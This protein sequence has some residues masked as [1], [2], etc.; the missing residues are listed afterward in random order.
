MTPVYEVQSSVLWLYSQLFL[1]YIECHLCRCG[2]LI[3]LCRGPHVRHTGKIKAMHVTK[4]SILTV[5]KKIVTL[6]VNKN[7]Q[8]HLVNF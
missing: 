3:D 7:K 6:L 2:P 1:Y 5:F 4:V 8:R